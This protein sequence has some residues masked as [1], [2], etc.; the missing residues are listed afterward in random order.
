MKE[1]PESSVKLFEKGHEMLSQFLDAA[2][3]GRLTKENTS[4]VPIGLSWY[5]VSGPSIDFS[6]GYMWAKFSEEAHKETWTDL[7]LPEFNS[8]IE[9]QQ[10]QARQA[11]QD[12]NCEVLLK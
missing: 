4:N 10:A 7:E 6:L 1:P 11:Y 12:K 9:L 5:F 2:K 3:S 8:Q